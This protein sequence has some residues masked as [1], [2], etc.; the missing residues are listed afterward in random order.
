MRTTRCKRSKDTP[1]VTEPGSRIKLIKS[2]PTSEDY[3]L[4]QEE[5]SGALSMGTS[6]K[7]TEGETGALLALDFLLL[8][9]LD[10]EK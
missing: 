9:G 10:Q 6:E 5:E 1:K 2:G 3:F 8:S 7:G 4:N